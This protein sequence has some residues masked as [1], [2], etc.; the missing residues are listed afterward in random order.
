[1]GIVVIAEMSLVGSLSDQIGDCPIACLF[2]PVLLH[3]LT[4]LH[5]ASFSAG[6]PT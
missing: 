2:G 1:M 4:F 6:S 5:L 3:E